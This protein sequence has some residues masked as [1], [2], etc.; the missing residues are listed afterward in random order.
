MTSQQLLG[1]AAFRIDPRKLSELTSGQRILAKGADTQS[2]WIGDTGETYIV[3]H[4]G[5]M[6]TESRY[7]SNSVLKVKVDTLPVRAALQV[8]DDLSRIA[9]A[10]SQPA[11][12]RVARAFRLPVL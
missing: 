10:V 1:V 11:D 2:F 4:D 12:A 3:N 5:W 9:P 7:A 6:I 8:R